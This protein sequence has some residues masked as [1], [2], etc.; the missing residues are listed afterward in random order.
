MQQGI[1]MGL[2]DGLEK[3]I[4]EHGSAAILKERIT[5]AN[6]KYAA[7]EA[8]LSECE[9]AKIKL[10]SENDALR[11]N[12]EKAEDEVQNLKKLTEKSHGER[13]EEV[14]EKILLAVAQNEDSTDQY[15]AQITGVTALI[16]TYHLEELKTL[17]MV[18]VS[19][20]MGSEWAGTSSNTNWSVSQSG[21]AYLVRHALIA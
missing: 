12:L 2:L 1:S 4:T 13:L 9:A 6:D 8:K 18:T 17:N 7:L 11:L 14:R 3:L 19:Y 21:L 5:L 16:N 10:H 20:I 15:I